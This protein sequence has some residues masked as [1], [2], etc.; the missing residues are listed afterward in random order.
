MVEKISTGIFGLD[1]ILHGG[2]RPNTLTVLIGSSG[3]GKT[4][5][6]LQFLLEG[7]H[8][9]EDALY[10]TLEEPPEQIVEEAILMGWNDVEKY[11]DEGKLIFLKTVGKDFK[12]FIEDDLPDIVDEYY[13]SSKGKK[14]RII[15][16][17]LTPLLWVTPNR[18]EQR[19]LLVKLFSLFKKGGT[20]VATVEQHTV[21]KDEITPDREVTLPIFLSDY[22][23]IFQFL[24]LGAE[25]NRGLRV[26]KTRGSSHY[27]GVYPVQITE[28]FG[29]VV[30]ASFK[31][32]KATQEEIDILNH[33]EYLISN[34][35][36]PE[37]E[38]LMRCFQ[39]FKKKYQTYK[40][41]ESPEEILN[42]IL[43]SKQIIT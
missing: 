40:W 35:N 28:G 29:I 4:L 32:T 3:T 15:I 24:G 10:A 5:F 2:L 30:L 36:I 26:I 8:H 34:A 11:A 16:D 9:G 27:E 25:Y 38:F 21:T 18:A 7:L 1:T 12:K 22:A 33:A 43:R 17:P 31:Q 39:R 13:R 41:L 6:S 20:V 19:D 23:F 37:K 42:T 14:R